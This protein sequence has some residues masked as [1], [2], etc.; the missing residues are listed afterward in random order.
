MSDK[1][2]LNVSEQIPYGFRFPYFPDG[3]L[4]STHKLDLDSEVFYNENYNHRIADDMFHDSW[5]SER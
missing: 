3:T 4:V 5:L 1:L 2:G